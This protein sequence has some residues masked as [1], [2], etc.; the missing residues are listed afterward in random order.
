[1]V[2]MLH[3]LYF[4]CTSGA[5]QG[6]GGGDGYGVH[7][8]HG[9]GIEVARMCVL[10]SGERGAPRSLRTEGGATWMWLGLVTSGKGQQS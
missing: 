6:Q 7:G 5:H 8:V 2:F 10:L 9:V 4:V 1:M 3:K